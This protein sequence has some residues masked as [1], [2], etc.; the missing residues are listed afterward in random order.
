NDRSHC[1]NNSRQ[2][3]GHPDTAPDRNSR[4]PRALRRKT[5][6]AK[7]TAKRRAMNQKQEKKRGDNKNTRRAR[8]AEI[9]FQPHRRRQ[10]R[11]PSK[12][13]ESVRDS[14]GQPAKQRKC[15]ERDDERRQPEPRY[16]TRVESPGK[17]ANS[18]GANSSNGNRQMR[19]TPEFSKQDRAQSEQ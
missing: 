11:T 1:R 16:Q 6:R 18:N 2:H 3:V 8:N 9:A 17:H 5:N 12:G 10:T 14:F 15:P 7:R 4:K 13:A 19:I